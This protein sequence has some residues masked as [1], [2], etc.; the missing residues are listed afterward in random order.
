MQQS[1]SAYAHIDPTLLR[2]ASDEK[3]AHEEKIRSQIDDD[4]GL[5][6]LI[7][8]EDNRVGFVFRKGGTAVAVDDVDRD[9]TGTGPNK[10]KDQGLTSVASP[11]VLD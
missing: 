3:A 9:T 2:E 7:R 8:E 1:L 11:I 6:P 4:E 10:G 5:W